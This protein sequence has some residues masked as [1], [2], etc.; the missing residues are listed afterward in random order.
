VIFENINMIGTDQFTL[1][2]RPL[3]TNAKVKIKNLI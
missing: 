2:G 3:V 1:L